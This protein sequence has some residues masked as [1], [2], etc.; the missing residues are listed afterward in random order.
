MFIYWVIN[1]V[2]IKQKIINFTG[3]KSR[4]HVGWLGIYLER[5]NLSKYK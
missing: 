2:E 4:Q 5:D 3:Y 1:E